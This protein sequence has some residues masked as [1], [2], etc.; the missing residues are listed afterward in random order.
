MQQNTI[1]VEFPSKALTK[2]SEHAISELLP[3]EQ[4]LS[5]EQQ[6]REKFPNGYDGP[7]RV[8]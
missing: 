6:Q 4:P 2:L 3:K 7:R 1:N 8:H 5:Q